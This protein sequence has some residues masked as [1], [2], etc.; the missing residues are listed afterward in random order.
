MRKPFGGPLA[1]AFCLIVFGLFVP[2]AN[3]T[4]VKFACT[5][6]ACQTGADVGTVSY[7]G[8]N[9]SSDGTGI[10]V[11][12]TQGPYSIATQFTLTF[13]TSTGNVTVTDGTVANTLTGTIQSFTVSSGTQ[14]TLTLHVNWSSLP[15]VVQ[16][17]LGTPTGL[18]STAI[19]LN[20][21]IVTGTPTSNV[22]VSQVILGILP[23]PEPISLTLFGSG[24]IMIGGVL[25]RRSRK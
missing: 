21:D 16:S 1:V 10:A 15:G 5:G 19:T 2:R 3:A 7:D 12:N 22:N 23:T 9:F 11:F 24:L 14:T 13:N 25:R 4:E 18:N 17:F 20:V 6:S 8:T